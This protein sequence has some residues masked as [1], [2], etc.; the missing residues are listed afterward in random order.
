MGVTNIRCPRELI[1]RGSSMPCLMS[2]L[3]CHFLLDGSADTDLDL[4]R[5]ASRLLHGLIDQWVTLDASGNIDSDRSGV[6]PC[7][8]P[9]IHIPESIRSCHR[10]RQKLGELGSGVVCFL[11]VEGLQG[12]RS[13]KLVVRGSV[14]QIAELAFFEAANGFNVVFGGLLLQRQLAVLGSGNSKV[15]FVRVKNLGELVE[16]NGEAGGEMGAQEVVWVCY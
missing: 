15:S 7:N 4:A 1:G 2:E 5:Y 14:E 11:V 9:R 8:N 10:N 6:S 12:A 16:K 3:G 13:Q